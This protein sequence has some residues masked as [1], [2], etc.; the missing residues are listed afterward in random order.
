M[1]DLV[2]LS[3]E[4][5]ELQRAEDGVHLLL[6]ASRVL[7]GSL[8]YRTTLGNVARL[9][10][11]TLADWCLVSVCEQ[12]ELRR[13]AVAHGDPAKEHILQELQQRYPASPT[14]PQARVMQSGEAELVPEITEEILR[15]RTIDE[16][17]RELIRA[18]GI[19]SYMAVPLKVNEAILGVITFASASRSYDSQ[20]F[21]LAKNIASSAAVAID[22]AQLHEGANAAS[23]AK[24]NFLAVMSHELRTPLS[25]I[26][27]YADLLEAGIPDPMTPKQREQVGRI[28]LRAYDLL[29]IIEEILAF[30]RMETGEERFHFE[31]VDLGALIDDVARVARPMAEERGLELETQAPARPAVVRTDANK[32]RQILVDLLSNAVKFTK[33]GHIGLEAHMTNG[34]ASF[35]VSDTGIGIAPE[36]YEKIFEPFFQVE[37]ALTREKGGT[38]IGLAVARKLA[39]HLGGDITVES[40]PHEGSTFIVTIP[41]HP[42]ETNTQP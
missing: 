35:R 36:Y 8:D 41:S 2:S 5:A 37:E 32:A 20:D 1:A 10:V 38:G 3:I 29:R 22:N 18:A 42:E 30:S 33:E 7:A 23:R 12:G 26:T 11:P 15:D 27:G 39:R 6:E 40:K 14:S 17:H 21:A 13:V 28:R 9:A 16:G 4:S 34:S 25:A 31:D 19:R 24:S